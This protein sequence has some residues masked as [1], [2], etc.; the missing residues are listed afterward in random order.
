[1]SCASCVVCGGAALQVREEGRRPPPKEE[2]VGLGK[3]GPL[4]F[5]NKP[6]TRRAAGTAAAAAAEA[7]EGRES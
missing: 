6:P 3:L 4:R 1:M 5:R 2:R 7:A